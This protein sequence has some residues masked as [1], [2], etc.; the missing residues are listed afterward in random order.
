[1]SNYLTTA[2]ANTTY[3]PKTDMINYLIISSAIF[4]YQTKSNMINYL[5]PQQQQQ[6]INPLV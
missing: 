3:Q 2:T 4:T 1:M 6:H 5:T